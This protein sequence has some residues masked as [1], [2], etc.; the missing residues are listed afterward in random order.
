MTG[1]E[2]FDDVENSRMRYNTND[3]NP[4]ATTPPIVI[5]LEIKP[6]TSIRDMVDG[7]DNETNRKI[8][9]Q[10]FGCYHLGCYDVVTLDK[11]EHDHNTKAMPTYRWGLG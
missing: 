4:T 10:P 6:V 2:L 7:C 3:V 11:Q 8:L 9:Y 5:W 1:N